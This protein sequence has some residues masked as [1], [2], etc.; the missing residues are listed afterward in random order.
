MCSYFVFI[1]V[2]I[3]KKNAEFD[4]VLALNFSGLVVE[5]VLKWLCIHPRNTWNEPVILQGDEDT[6]MLKVH[7][8]PAL[9]EL[10]ISR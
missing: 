5:L 8:V 4:N 9:M 6:K 7:V 10:K 1:W 2:Q 3:Q